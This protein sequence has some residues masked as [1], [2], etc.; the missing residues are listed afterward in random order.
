MVRAM[1]KPAPNPSFPPCS[2]CGHTAGWTAT[3]RF[4]TERVWLVEPDGT[5]PVLLS[6]DDDHGE[7]DDIHCSGCHVTADRSLLPAIIHALAGG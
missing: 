7:W 1:T 3:F 5:E 6:E 4:Q 2:A